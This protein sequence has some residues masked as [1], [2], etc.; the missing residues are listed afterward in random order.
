LPDICD[1]ELGRWH[2]VPSKPP[3]I[4]EETIQLVDGTGLARIYYVKSG[5]LLPSRRGGADPAHHDALVGVVAVMSENGKRA[6]YAVGQFD[7]AMGSR[8]SFM[9]EK[10][11]MPRDT[12]LKMFS[13]D[14]MKSLRERAATLRLQ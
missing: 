8:L 5:S 11:K 4:L 6:L 13:R 10:V 2:S 7:E 1:D 3:V 9:V 12:A 14:H